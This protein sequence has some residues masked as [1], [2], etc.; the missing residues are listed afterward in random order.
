MANKDVR[1][2]TYAVT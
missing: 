2:Y 1:I